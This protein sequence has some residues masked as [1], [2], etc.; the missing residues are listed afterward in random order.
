MS[1]VVSVRINFWPVLSS[2]PLGYFEPSQLSHP[3]QTR[4]NDSLKDRSIYTRS[5]F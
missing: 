2:G 3:L 1:P 5:T 4:P